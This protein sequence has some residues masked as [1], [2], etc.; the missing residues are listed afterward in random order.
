MWNTFIYLLSYIKK[1]EVINCYLSQNCLVL[2]N[3]T[4]FMV[5][6]SWN[7]CLQYNRMTK[8]W[9]KMSHKI[10]WKSIVVRWAAFVSATPSQLLSNCISISETLSR[11]L[12]NNCALYV[13]RGVWDCSVLLN[14]T[15]CRF[16]PPLHYNN[17]TVNYLKLFQ[18]YRK[19]IAYYK[20]WAI[21]LEK[22]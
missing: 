5:D 6:V 2:F 8:R 14:C 12:S 19:R 10:H 18:A 4:V 21:F 3:V 11:T 20:L 13:V 7:I 16:C 9:W 1:V 22:S 15:F 17:G